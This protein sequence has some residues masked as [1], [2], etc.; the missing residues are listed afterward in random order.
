MTA[1]IEPP[2]CCSPQSRAPRSGSTIDSAS[3]HL[4]FQMRPASR[5][6]GPIKVSVP[7]EC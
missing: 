5:L 3:G 2:S 4:P 7:T 1:A 6:L